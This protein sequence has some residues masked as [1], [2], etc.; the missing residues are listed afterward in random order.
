MIAVNVWLITVSLTGCPPS[1]MPQ[2][3]SL[4]PRLL[5]IVVMVCS[6]RSL[7]NSH[8]DNIPPDALL[9]TGTETLPQGTY[10][11][12]VCIGSSRF[13]RAVDKLVF[14]TRRQS[15][16]ENPWRMGV[17]K[18][19]PGGYR[20]PSSELQYHGFSITCATL[21]LQHQMPQASTK[22]Q[23]HWSCCEP[24]EPP[25]E[26]GLAARAQSEIAESDT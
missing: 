10:G 16:V 19:K 11:T 21:D 6:A 17:P 3:G 14:Q 15:N 20:G 1:T 7:A 26:S 5:W 9:K 13:P 12:L 22:S 8:T 23:V 18:T 2:H 4:A 25:E 24:I